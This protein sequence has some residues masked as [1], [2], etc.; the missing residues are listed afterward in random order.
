MLSRG[1]RSLPVHPAKKRKHSESPPNTLNAQMLNGLIK[2]EPGMGSVPLNPDRAPTPPWHQP[3]ALSPGTGLFAPPFFFL[4]PSYPQHANPQC[5]PGGVRPIW[6]PKEG[7]A[8]QWVHPG[9]NLVPSGNVQTTLVASFRSY[10][11]GH[12]IRGIKI[13]IFPFTTGLIQDN[14]SLNGSYL[15]PNYQSIKWQPHQQN[16]W[17]TLYDANYKEL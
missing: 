13:G 17:A 16:K 1:P 14:D 9:P 15:D 6:N 2:Q 11:I 12:S 5:Q 10:P 7:T 3:G 4:F 8:G